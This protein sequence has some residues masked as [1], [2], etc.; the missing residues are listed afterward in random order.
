MIYIYSAKVNVMRFIVRLLFVLLLLLFASCETKSIEEYSLDIQVEKNGRV[1]IYT[2]LNANQYSCMQLSGPKVYFEILKSGSL[3]IK[4]N[5]LLSEEDFIFQLVTQHREYSRIIKYHVRLHPYINLAPASTDD[6]N[7][8]LGRD[9]DSDGDG[10]SDIDEKNHNTDPLDSNS[11][12]NDLLKIIN[13]TS[14]L[15]ALHASALEFFPKNT[16]GIRRTDYRLWSQGI[17]HM[18]NGFYLMSQNLKEKDD[19]NISRD[20]YTL[21]NLYNANGESIGNVQIDYPS[22]GQDLSIE[23]ISENIYYLYS[24]SPNRGHIAKFKLDTSNIDFNDLTPR[25]TVLNIR[26][27]EEVDLN[28][29]ASSITASLNK[30]KNKIVSAGYMPGGKKL[31]ISISNKLDLQILNSFEFNIEGSNKGFFNQGIAMYEDKIFLLRGH[32]YTDEIRNRKKLFV[33]DANSGELLNSYTFSLI[34][35]ND[36][37]RI[38]PEGLMIKN[39]KLFVCLP[40]RLNGNNEQKIRL[41]KLLDIK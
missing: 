34:N 26:F 21:F 41:Y 38:E 8:S 7:D 23:K 29:D 32:Y 10:V 33:F 30:T 24:A 5:H 35:Y 25:D 15:S 4:V 36:F 40:T 3:E 6:I 19:S 22:H 31:K 13:D 39:K 12:P 2:G 14:T 28:I 11:K 16:H 9:Y 37:N 17:A 1:I 20:T 18:K 27:M